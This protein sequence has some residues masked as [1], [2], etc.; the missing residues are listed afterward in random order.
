MPKDWRSTGGTDWQNVQSL[1][2]DSYR[3]G[4]CSYDVASA[5][6][7]A[8]R[9]GLAVV[10]ICP[11]CNGPTF[12]SHD[13]RQWPGPKLGANM[14]KLPT[15]VGAIYEE[16]RS[17]VTVNA[18][19]ATVLLCRKLLM[20]VAVEKGAPK[21][22]A[23]LEYVNWLIQERYAPKGAENWL[24]YIRRRSNEANHQIS[25]M[26]ATDAKALILLTEQLL[27]NV[28][29]LADSAPPQPASQ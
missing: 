20:H 17:S 26:E 21:D 1:P 16:A 24:D 22:K 28:Y 23:F 15:D 11:Q 14:S 13:G 27:R 8:A 7:L 4:Y 19:T 5:H 29:E 3:C 2:P 18:F 9:D 10:R 25:I 6:G 12:F